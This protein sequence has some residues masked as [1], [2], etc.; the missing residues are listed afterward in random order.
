MKILDD[1][2]LSR[3]IPVYK[4][5]GNIAEVGNY[6]PIS[7]ICHL[8]KVMEKEVRKQII[9]YLM[10]HSLITE[11][12]SAFLERHNTQTSL[13]RVTDDWLWNMNDRLVTGICALD[14]KTVLISPTMISYVKTLEYYGF[15]KNAVHWFKSYV[16][17]RGHKVCYNNEWS[18]IKYVVIGVPQGSVLG[19]ALFYP[20]LRILVI[21]RNGQL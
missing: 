6:W 16:S 20:T 1:W 13:H 4:G 18:E 21:L 3:V 9:E 5:E 2:K 19:P 15:N 8:A 7:V 11:D 12:Q 10:E 14:I 17:T